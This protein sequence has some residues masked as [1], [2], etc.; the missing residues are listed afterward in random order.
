MADNT[1]AKPKEESIVQVKLDRPYFTNGGAFGYEEQ[2]REGKKV[3]VFTGIA[4]VPESV[5]DDLNRRQDTFR[6][7]QTELLANRG[8]ADD[9]SNG[10]QVFL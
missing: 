4:N 10:T 2:E 9:D 5:A 6:Q 1:D 8:N 3:Q 7:Y